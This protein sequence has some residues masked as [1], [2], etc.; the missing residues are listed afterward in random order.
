[1]RRRKRSW[2]EDSRPRPLFLFFSVCFPLLPLSP[3]YLFRDFRPCI[4][5]ISHQCHI[6]IANTIINSPRPPPPTS[7]LSHL[8]ICIQLTSNSINPNMNTQIWMCPNLQGTMSIY[9]LLLDHQ[10]TA[11]MFTITKTKSY[12]IITRWNECPWPNV[13]RDKLNGCLVT[14]LF[15][16]ATYLD[17]RSYVLPW[18][19]SIFTEHSQ[20]TTN[21]IHFICDCTYCTP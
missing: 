4:I 5:V 1:M 11:S 2:K 19:N 18:W 8:H 13:R 17:I 10:L 9:S 7:T 15:S 14:S 21:A 3:L 6:Q 20:S 12:S 16:I